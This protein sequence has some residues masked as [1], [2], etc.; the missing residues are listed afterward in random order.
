M[1]PSQGLGISVG[2]FAWL[3][4]ATGALA[5]GNPI[6]GTLVSYSA[7]TIALAA[8]GNTAALPPNLP[9]YQT[10]ATC[11]R[12]PVPPLHGKELNPREPCFTTPS[13][14]KNRV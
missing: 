6:T 7:P 5:T 4:F 8:G 11:N 12:S 13:A 10:I 3:S 1:R 14:S 2:V 9:N